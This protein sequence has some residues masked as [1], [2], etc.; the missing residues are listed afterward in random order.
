MDAATFDT[1][2][3]SLKARVPFR[4][5]TVSLINGD[6][7]EVDYPGVLVVR[8]GAAAFIGSGHVVSIF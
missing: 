5:F 7:F 4:A 6:R 3:N 8:E 1:T 2:L